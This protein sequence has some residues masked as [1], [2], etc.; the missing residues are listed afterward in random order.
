MRLQD[1]VVSLCMQ[2]PISKIRQMYFTAKPSVTVKEEHLLL[3]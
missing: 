1:I 3:K 2:A